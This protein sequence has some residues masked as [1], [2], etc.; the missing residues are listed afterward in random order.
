MFSFLPGYDATGRGGVGGGLCDFVSG[1]GGGHGIPSEGVNRFGLI[2]FADLLID[3]TLDSFLAIG[4]GDSL[5]C[6]CGDG[7]CPDAVVIA[8]ATHGIGGSNFKL[9]HFRVLSFVFRSLDYGIIIHY[10]LCIVNNFHTDSGV[11]LHKVQCMVL[12]I[13]YIVFCV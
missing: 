13:L 12:V 9:L 1:Q 4:K 2:P 6:A 10:Y 3:S 11:I 5:R 8:D 7:V